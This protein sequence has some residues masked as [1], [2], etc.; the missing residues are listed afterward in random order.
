MECGL[1]WVGLGRGDVVSGLVVHVTSLDMGCRFTLYCSRS[2]GRARTSQCI[3]VNPQS[4][5]QAQKETPL[6]DTTLSMR[7]GIGLRDNQDKHVADH[8]FTDD[9]LHHNFADCSEQQR[10]SGRAGRLHGLLWYQGCEKR[11]A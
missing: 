2:N 9:A 7:I 1:G 5:L 11:H 10:G 8:E 3:S 4:M 6:A